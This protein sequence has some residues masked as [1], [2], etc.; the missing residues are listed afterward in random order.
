MDVAT[1]LSFARI[2]RRRGDRRAAANGRTDPD[3]RCRAGGDF[4]QPA[5]RKGNNERRCDRREDNENGVPSDLQHGYKVHAESEEYDAPL[6]YLFRG[7]ADAA[8]QPFRTP[9]KGDDHADDNG[10]YGT[11][12]DGDKLSQKPCGYGDDRTQRNA[13]ND[14]FDIIPSLV[15]KFLFP[16][17]TAFAR[18]VFLRGDFCR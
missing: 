10:K 16:A 11:A 1:S 15:P 6:Q 12:D 18:A 9:E 7:E 3:E 4:E 2:T 13:R 17:R 8:F 14:R 5:H